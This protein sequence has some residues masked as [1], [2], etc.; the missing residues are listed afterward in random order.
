M[1]SLSK[2]VLAAKAA[3]KAFIGGGDWAASDRPGNIYSSGRRR[4]HWLPGTNINWDL[5]T[6]DLW[7]NPAVQAC[8]NWIDRN[9]TQADPIVREKVKDNR[10]QIVPD[11]PLID[12]IQ[13]PNPEYDGSILLQSL[14]LSLETN[15]NAFAVIERDKSGQARELWYVP[16]HRMWPWTDP[17]NDQNVVDYYRY[18]VKNGQ[19]KVPPSDV[20][21]LKYGLDPYDTRLG[22][23][24]LASAARGVYSLQ[25]ANNYRA[26]ILRNG[27]ALGV[28]ISGKTPDVVFDP[29]ELVERYNAKQGGDNAGSAF[30][31]EAPLDFTFPRNSPEDMAMETIE[32]RPESDI[33]ALIGIPPQ[34]AGLHVGRLSKTYAN[35]TQ[36]REA[37]W[38]EKLIPLGSMIAWQM[39]HKLLPEFAGSSSP[40]A[41][42]AYLKQYKMDFNYDAVRQLQPDKDALHERL[43][44]DWLA[45]L[46]TL[47]EWKEA[48]DRVPAPGD[49]KIHY[50]DYVA[51]QQVS[52]T[53]LGLAKSLGL[54]DRW[55]KRKQKYIADDWA[56]KIISQIEE[57]NGNI[58]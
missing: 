47:A 57:L 31:V 56:G 20:L 49:D 12:L 52:A 37:A 15:G 45:N 27:G 36:A 53:S 26:N 16:H 2:R 25:Q 23:A 3:F 28:I 6:G 30:A 5:V 38:E 50:M 8:L 1:A 46:I 33:C 19:V 32:D 58:Q 40:E 48:T 24:P 22:L 29:A 10:W 42:K 34:V 39:G 4:S 43:R 9:F 55:D 54:N 7:T 17:G 13:D 35:V 41:A 18:W 11:H 44:R 51:A 14:I 21:H